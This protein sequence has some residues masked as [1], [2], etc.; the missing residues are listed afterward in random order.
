MVRTFILVSGYTGQDLD[1]S[2]G[3]T[4]KEVRFNMTHIYLRES[5]I[6]RGRFS[7]SLLVVEEL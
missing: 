3:M 7:F 4:L 5:N 2:W 1:L 6:G